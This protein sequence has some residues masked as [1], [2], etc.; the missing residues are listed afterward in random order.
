MKKMLTIAFLLLILSSCSNKNIIKIEIYKAEEKT[1]AKIETEKITYEYFYINGKDVI[2]NDENGE[3]IKHLTDKKRVAL[4]KSTGDTAEIEDRIDRG[5]INREYLTKQATSTPVKKYKGA[6]YGTYY[7]KDEK[8]KN[9][10]KVRGIYLAPS[11]V[12]SIDQVLKNMENTRLN[13]LVI[14]YKSDSGNVFFDSAVAK[15]ILPQAN[16]P[17][18]H[19]VAGYIKK[20][21]DKGHYL[22][23]RI[24]VF[25]SPIYAKAF[26]DKVITNKNN[27]P[28]VHDGV[29]WVN[30]YDR[31]FWKYIVELSKE[32][33]EV[34]FDEIQYDY[35]RF[36]DVVDSRV[37]IKNDKKESKTSA[38]QNFIKFARKSIRDKSKI[39][40]ADVFGWS[41]TAIDDIGIGQHWEAITNVSDVICP[42][43]YPSHYGRG[44]FGLKDPNSAPYQLMKHAIK[45]AIKRNSNVTTPAILRPW[46]QDFSYTQK[47]VEAQIRALK[48]NGVDEYLL[49]NAGGYYHYGA[50]KK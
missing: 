19:D 12:N 5:F 45:D 7:S 44:I 36:P 10:R 40:S 49:W 25:K 8:L 22:I 37:N 42:M 46:I 33:L 23:A 15:R 43:F 32:A 11:K 2:L 29:Y 16:K 18:V 28:L 17:I 41:A 26:K 48:E 21:K 4:I 1:E 35:V 14:D 34:G 47:D 20:I 50:L 13:A 30:P 24:V 9:Y 27:T 6:D 3:K 39:I 31:D 38:I